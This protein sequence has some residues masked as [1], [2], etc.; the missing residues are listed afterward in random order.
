MDKDI[1]RYLNNNITFLD[2]RLTIPRSV[3]LPDKLRGLIK[4]GYTIFNCP[5]FKIKDRTISSGV[6]I[7]V[8]N[9]EMGDSQELKI[10][11]N[12]NFQYNS[13]DYNRGMITIDLIGI[14]ELGNTME[15]EGI[16]Y[17]TVNLSCKTRLSKVLPKLSKSVSKTDMINYINEYGDGDI[18]EWTS[19]SY[20][21]I[22][23]LYKAVQKGKKV[24]KVHFE[25]VV[26]HD[27]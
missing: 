9:M 8:D 3:D 23:H 26:D 10:S 1:A 6:Y 22:E 18:P 2:D 15:L 11:S 7:I 25:W 21:E 20:K 14:S 16:F 24:K 13:H 19:Y 27:K 17:H 12:P 4:A 5:T